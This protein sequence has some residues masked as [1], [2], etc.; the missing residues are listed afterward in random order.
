MKLL[1]TLS[2][3]V[4]VSYGHMCLLNP[5]QRNGTVPDTELKTPG[6]SYCLRL[7]GPC[8]G[9]NADRNPVGTIYRGEQGT[10]VLEK[11]LNHFN[12]TSGA[13]NFTLTLLNE[14]GKKVVDL[15]S[16]ADDDSDSGSIYQIR[17]T[18][19]ASQP[20][21]KYVVQAVYNTNNPS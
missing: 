14:A 18:I 10:A 20:D 19:P 6:S 16:V 12:K 13:G 15:G 1:I 3:L 8:G 17:Y 11:N 9:I 5:Y 21:G 7:T 4:A 2:L